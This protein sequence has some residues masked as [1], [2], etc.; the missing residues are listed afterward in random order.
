MPSTVVE[1]VG[2]RLVDQRRMLELLVAANSGRRADSRRT[3]EAIVAAFVRHADWATGAITVP[4]ETIGAE[5]GEACGRAPFSH[6]TVGRVVA[7]AIAAGVLV[8]PAGMGG[9][10]RVAFGGAR[11]QCPTYFVVDPADLRTPPSHVSETVPLSGTRSLYKGPKF[12]E[13]SKFDASVVPATADERRTAATW[14]RARLFVGV[15]PNWKMAAMMARQ[16]A[17][18]LSPAEILRRACLEPDGSTLRDLPVA[19]AARTAAL[20]RSRHATVADMLLGIIG[21]RLS[22]W[23]DVPPRRQRP[24]T[25]RSA[26]LPTGARTAPTSADALEALARLGLRAG[27]LR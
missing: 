21:K 8:C 12:S 25:R 4:H 2:G 11:N 24:P 22:A 18:G 3:W 9:M 13:L 1:Q 20:G 7:A 15:V 16:F 6:D 19:D 10:S 27:A 23:R 17:A 14:L 5:A 26:A